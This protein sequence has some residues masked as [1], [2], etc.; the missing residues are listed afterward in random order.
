[1]KR[2]EH[3]RSGVPSVHEFRIARPGDGGVRWIKSTAFPLRDEHGHVQRIG[4]ISADITE[5]RQS[6]GH[7][8]VLL[9]ELQHRVRNIMAMILS[10]TIRTA[11][12]AASVQDYANL[13]TGRLTA[14][15]R[16]QALLTRA[17][18]AGADLATIVRDEIAAHAQHHS[19]YELAGP[20]IVLS[21]KAAEVITLAM[22]ELAT[23][24]LKHGALSVATGHVTVSWR[25]ESRDAQPWV[26]LD[27]LERGTPAKSARPTSATPR[28]FG[29]QLIEERIPYELRGVGQLHVE[30]GGARCH[31]EFPLTTGTSVLETDAPL[32][33]TLARGVLDMSGE[34]DLSGLRVLVVED[35]FYLARD[36]RRALRGAGAE[37]IGPSESEASALERLREQRPHVAV[38]DV[39]LG[40]GP[41]FRLAGILRDERIPFVFVTGYDGGTIPT[42]F[43]QVPR[44]EKPT[45]LRR[46]VRTVAQ[47]A[48]RVPSKHSAA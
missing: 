36:A 41:S 28:G 29:S 5:A 45:E 31:L 35:D 24:A 6:A 10:I 2:L 32:R 12:T 8:A 43:A 11:R 38:V 7:Q 22:H 30:P 16:T 1:L 46:I 3:V 34:P 15:A 18:N 20:K 17:P 14:L 4:G 33:S 26:V 40:G 25:V 47:I 48:G 9:A 23:N 19:Q 27:W 37:V 44:L 13:M 42:D 39:D 21:P